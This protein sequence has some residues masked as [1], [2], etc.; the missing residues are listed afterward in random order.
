MKNSCA[1]MIEPRN[2]LARAPLRLRQRAEFIH[3]GKGKRLHR[4]AFTLQ[5]ACRQQILGP[6]DQN[7]DQNIASAPENPGPRFG[8]TVT[9]KTG[10]AVK[11]NRIRRRL[12]EALR[13]SGTLSARPG[14]DYVIVART[15][16]LTTPFADLQAELNRALAKIFESKTSKQDAAV[17]PREKS[18]SRSCTLKG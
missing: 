1:P 6:Q 4:A 11:R 15:Q 9:K 7:Q 18:K 12:K 10:N 5:A 16:V 17:R 14:H 13:L 3:V 2:K 8:F